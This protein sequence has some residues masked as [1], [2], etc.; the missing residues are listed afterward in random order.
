VYSE[1]SHRLALSLAR[2]GKLAPLVREAI[3]QEMGC[4]SGNVRLANL[5]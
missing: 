1:P 4:N 5:L 3:C 2:Q